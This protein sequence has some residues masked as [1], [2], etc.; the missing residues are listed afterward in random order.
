[1]IPWLGV[2][3][4]LRI[5]RW[6]R[7]RRRGFPW[8]DD[9]DAWTTLLAEMLLRRTRAA[10]VAAELPSLTRKYPTPLAMANA[11]LDQVRADLRSLGLVWRADNVAAAASKIVKHHGGLVPGN[12]AAL[13]DLPGVGPYVAAATMAGT[14]RSRVTL[15]DTNTVRVARRVAGL[16]RGRDP[17]RGRETRDA[18][19]ELLG[20]PAVAR[21]WWAVLDL[22]HST[23]LVRSPRCWECPIASR[24][25]TGRGIAI[26]D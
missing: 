17:R 15:I 6:F 18:V 9:R 23:C 7:T 4:R 21:D 24:C 11:P 26:L 14:T 12:M 19:D 3:R 10:Q 13:L 25:A 5:R 2:D 1:M 8:R 22:A 16:P 20:G